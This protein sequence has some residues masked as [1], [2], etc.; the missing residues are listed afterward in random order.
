MDKIDD[1]TGHTLNAIISCAKAW[2]IAILN[3]LLTIRRI[4]CIS[5]EINCLGVW[6]SPCWARVVPPKDRLEIK[7]ATNRGI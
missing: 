7:E 3:V 1:K 6:L 4:I 5:I 2:I